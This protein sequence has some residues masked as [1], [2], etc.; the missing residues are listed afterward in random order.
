MPF[1]GFIVPQLAGRFAADAPETGLILLRAIGVA[2]QIF[3]KAGILA[4]CA[5]ILIWS[6]TA[7][8]AKRARATAII[9]LPAALRP[10]GLLLFTDQVLHPQSLMMIFSLH[11]LWYPAAASGRR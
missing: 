1:D 6:C 4:H 5:A 9:G 11:A 2:I 10:A 7:W 8:K 3:S